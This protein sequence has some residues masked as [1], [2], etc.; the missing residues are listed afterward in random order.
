M[1]NPSSKRLLLIALFTIALIILV[2][3]AWWFFYQNTREMLDQQLGRRLSAVGQATSAGISAETTGKLAAGDFTAY[4]EIVDLL[5]RVQSADSLAGLFVLNQSY[6]YLASTDIENDSLY[7][8][9]ELNGPYL[10]SLFFAL[11]PVP[12][13]SPSYQSGDIYLKTAFVPLLDSSYFVAAVLGVEANVDYFQVLD[14]LRNS[15]IFSTAVSVMGGLLFGLIFVSYQRRVNSIQ[16]RLF[17]NETHSYLGRMVAVVSH[18]IKN[19]LMIIRASAE[20]LK[21]RADSEESRFVIEEVDRLNSI[22]TG[23]LDFAR[24][25]SGTNGEASLIHEPVG[26]LSL[27]ELSNELKKHLSDKYSGQQVDWLSDDIDPALTIRSYRRALRQTLLNLLINAAES[28]RDKGCPIRI[29]LKVETDNP[30]RVLL[31]VVDHGPGMEPKELKRVFDPFYTTRMSG[32]GLGLFLSKNIVEQMNGRLLIESGP[33]RG[34]TVIVDLPREIH[35]S[36]KTE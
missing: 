17:M 31:K 23:Y 15:L 24:S 6:E 2:N 21:K 28:C 30:E 16:Q 27:Y 26:D 14:D 29:G 12:I 1:T 33:D 3:L 25:S 32:S 11:D 9:K 18:E 8:L 36:G 10:D 22:V 5:T 7:I 4:L 34:T 13:V 19:P 35:S 20:R